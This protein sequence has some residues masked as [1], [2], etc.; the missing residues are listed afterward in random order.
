[1]HSIPLGQ[2]TEYRFDYDASLL[3]PIPRALGREKLGIDESQFVGVD[4]W[5]AYEISWLNSRG[6]PLVRLAR[7]VVPCDSPCIV[8]SKSLKLYFN[9]FNQSTFDSEAMVKDLMQRDISHCVGADVQLFLLPVDDSEA[10]IPSIMPGTC[11]DSQQISCDQYQTDKSL[12]QCGEGRVTDERVYSHLLRSLCPVT[13]QPDWASVF[14]QY[15][16]QRIDEASL[17]R[18]IVSFRN[19]QDFHELCVETIF[20]HVWQQ[21]D[22]DQ[23]TVYAR[24]LRRGGIDISPLRSSHQVTLADWRQLRQ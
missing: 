23:L 24:Y 21:F 4:V 14:I 18:Y 3:A 8:E 17:L 16:G 10:F 1:V 9:S 11:L 5:N 19:Q 7:L 6:L 20:S 13:G 15:T 22:L 12:L 2:D